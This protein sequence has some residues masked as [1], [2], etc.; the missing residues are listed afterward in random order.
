MP[1]YL[2]VAIEHG[3]VILG[4]HENLQKEEIPPEYLWEDVEGLEMWWA[5]VED[6]RSD[7]RSES[8]SSNRQVVPDPDDEDGQ[9]D[10][11]MADNDI[12]RALKRQ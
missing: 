5:S 11:G 6:K 10:T 4:W 12:A 3:L 9:H 2:Q 1:W 8:D 7:G